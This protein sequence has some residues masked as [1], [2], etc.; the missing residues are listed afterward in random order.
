M[1]RRKRQGLGAT[2]TT[3][4]PLPGAQTRVCITRPVNRTKVTTA[5]DACSLLRRARNADRESFYVLAID[6]RNQVQ[7][8]EEVAR[9]SA[10]D[11]AVHP[12]EVFK[13]ATLLN[14]AAVIVAHNHPSGDTAPSEADV[15]LTQRL[16]AAGKLLGI[17]VL[18]HLVIGRTGCGSIADVDPMALQ[19]PRRYTVKRKRRR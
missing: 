14:A 6:S 12:R 10:G 17:P 16:V 2:T 11:V 19:G 13:V 1:A 7:G 5:A 18:D 4:S 9:G 15:E 3:C 8:V